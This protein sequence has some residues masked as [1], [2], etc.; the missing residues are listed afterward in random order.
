MARKPTVHELAR[1]AERG[2]IMRFTDAK[3]APMVKKMHARMDKDPNYAIKILHDAG[4]V[5]KRGN[6]TK[7]FGG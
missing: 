6:L 7:R 1:A 2:S 5:T 3:F 4:I